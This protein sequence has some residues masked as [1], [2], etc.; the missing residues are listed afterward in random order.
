MQVSRVHR[1][2]SGRRVIDRGTDSNS[3]IY[4]DLRCYG[5]HWIMRLITTLEQCQLIDLPHPS[6]QPWRFQ[7]LIDY[8]KGKNT[9]PTSAKLLILPHLRRNF[10]IS[11]PL[12]P[13][14]QLT[15]ADIEYHLKQYV[16]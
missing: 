1:V 14:R 2:W 6:G 9:P 4:S 16:L 11:I 3:S 8:R 12:D 13:R 15:L 5:F 10:G 7:F